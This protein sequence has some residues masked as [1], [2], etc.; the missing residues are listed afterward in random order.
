M[1]TQYLVERGLQAAWISAQSQSA[2]CQEWIGSDNDIY[3]EVF[4]D[5]YPAW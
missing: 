2:A 4:A 5:A 3:D 1:N